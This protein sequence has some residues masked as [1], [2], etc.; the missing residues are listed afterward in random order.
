M[1]QRGLAILLSVCMLTGGSGN[2]VYA[3][4]PQ[5]DIQTIG[6]VQ[7]EAEIGEAAETTG[8]LQEDGE[9]NTPGNE[10]GSTED[11]T[12]DK[13]DTTGDET[14]DKGDT[15]GDESGDKGDTAEGGEGE[16][17]SA[18]TGD[19]APAV[20]DNDTSTGEND[21]EDEIEVIEADTLSQNSASLLSMKEEEL[22]LTVDAPQTVTLGAG[23]QQWL[24]FTA[25]GEGIFRF[26]ST[27]EDVSYQDKY[28]NLYHDKNGSE[29][30]S[31]YG[32]GEN[33]NFNCTYRMETDETVYLRVRLNNS[34]VGGTFTVHA[35][36][37]TP[38]EFTVTQ[39]SEAFLYNSEGGSRVAS[40]GWQRIDGI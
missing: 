22:T 27:V 30:A 31:D 11:E 33:G 29:F 14:G 12:D 37:V 17:G 25:P 3:M 35:E 21:G 4:N 13:G 1:L 38:P 40:G 32:S 20:S 16:D 2:T 10:K 23:E 9:G 34:Y 8:G 28:V 24:T 6:V 15:T 26:Y 36:K 19:D 5:A 39:N 7:N 18:D